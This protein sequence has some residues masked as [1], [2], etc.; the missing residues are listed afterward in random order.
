M[1]IVDL[2]T[3][4][5]Q[6]FSVFNR[7]LKSSDSMVFVDGR[8]LM[9]DGPSS[10]ELTVGDTWYDCSDNISYVISDHGLTIKP[11]SAVVI[12]TEQL[13]GLPTNVFGLVTG[14]GKFIFQGVMVSSGKID[15]GFQDHLR[16]GL[17]NGGKEFVT[18]KRGDAFCS[19]CFFQ[20]ESNIDAPRRALPLIPRRVLSS[21]P[22]ARRLWL[23]AKREWGWLLTLLL[24]LLSLLGTLYGLRY[25]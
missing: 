19:C 13:V 22:F 18:I 5:T 17:Y 20:L 8:V 14:K 7:Y 1:S 10:L 6:D 12:D 23:F 11:S 4:L 16:I 24:A 9:V 2:K 3:R 25:R 15:P 21:L